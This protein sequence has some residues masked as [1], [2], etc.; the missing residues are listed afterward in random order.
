MVVRPIEPGFVLR[1]ALPRSILSVLAFA[2]AVTALARWTRR[3]DEEYL[4]EGIANEASKLYG[5]GGDAA[6]DGK[7][8]GRR[9]GEQKAL[10]PR[11]EDKIRRLIPDKCPDQLRLPFALWTREAVDQPADSNEGSKAT[12][13]EG[14]GLAAQRLEDRAAHRDVERVREHLVLGS[15]PASR[16]PSARRGRG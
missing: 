14:G 13:R 10:K 6:L 15:A 12:K 11:Q 5:E 7:K 4:G 3:D 1:S 8:R 16:P 9:P 2:Q